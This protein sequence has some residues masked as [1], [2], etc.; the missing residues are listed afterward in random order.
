MTAL[1]QVL[2]HLVGEEEN[3]EEIGL[4]WKEVYDMNWEWERDVRSKGRRVQEA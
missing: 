4:K 2:I 3:F 1:L